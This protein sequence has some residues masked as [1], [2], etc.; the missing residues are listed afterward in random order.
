[1]AIKCIE[2]DSD[3]SKAVENEVQLM[4]AMDHENI[5]KAYHYITYRHTLQLGSSRT[6]EDST[7]QQGQRERS[8]SGNNSSGVPAS[9][10]S[11]ATRK[12][13]QRE[14]QKQLSQLQRQLRHELGPKHQWLLDM[15]LGFT[16]EDACGFGGSSNS[17]LL[18]G[19]SA[20]AS[21]ELAAQSSSSAADTSAVPLS[22]LS[23]ATPA[24]ADSCSGVDWGVGGVDSSG[25]DAALLVRDTF[26][27]PVAR[28]SSCSSSVGAPKPVA[29]SEK[30]A[31]PHA[32]HQQQRQQEGPVLQQLHNPQPQQRQ[33]QPQQPQ[34][35]PQQ[36]QSQAQL[37]RLQDQLQQQ[38]QQQLPGS[39]QA[40]QQAP[41]LFPDALRN[42]DAIWRTSGASGSVHSS[43]DHPTTSRNGSFDTSTGLP[44]TPNQKAQLQRYLSRQQHLLQSNGM[45]VRSSSAAAPGLTDVQA[46]GAAGGSDGSSSSD[47]GSG[48]LGRAQRKA[49][50]VQRCRTYI[51]EGACWCVGHEAFQVS[52]LKFKVYVG[53][54]RIPVE[55]DLRTSK[56]GNL[57]PDLAI[58]G[59]GLCVIKWKLGEYKENM[60]MKHCNVPVC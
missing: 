30:E 4:L 54:S 47:T 60:L 35:Q 33:Q 18:E 57:A 1:V 55:M 16:G 43:P 40:T 20:C 25:P 28:G 8:G 11:N 15:H 27:P 58:R 38:P 7:V 49:Q 31:H 48:E 24:A 59:S 5:V 19:Y 9:P 17:D 6:S 3:T 14:Q 36:Q 46:R 42:A 22:P 23:C 2:H 39:E 56:N 34:Q 50:E 37:P 29:A 53:G 51:V 10:M 52:V 13:Q 41:Q 21:G 32:A 12:Q 26:P 45:R 44:L